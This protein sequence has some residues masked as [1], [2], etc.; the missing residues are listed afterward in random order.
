MIS[1]ISKPTDPETEAR[2]TDQGPDELLDL[3][4]GDGFRAEGEGT[5]Q[6]TCRAPANVVL[7]VGTAG[8]GKTTLLST[9]YLLFQK[10]PFAT[11][12]FAGSRTLVGLEKRVHNAR[13]ASNL[14]RPRTE[15]STFSELLHIRVRK[16][17]RSA[18]AKDVLLCDL[19]GEDFREARDS[20]DGCKRLM[21]IRRADTFVLLVNGAKLAKL[22]TRQQAKSDPIAIMRNVLDCGMLTET[23]EVDV[24]HTQWDL[25]MR[26][27]AQK[28]IEAF[29]DHVD[30]EIRRHFSSRVGSLRFARVA[31][32]SEEGTL[33]LGHGL[34]EPFQRWVDTPVGRARHLFR[35][36]Q[37][38]Q[39]ACEYDRY[40]DRYA[41]GQTEEVAT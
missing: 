11:Y 24:L 9:L 25:V 33:P 39:G 18:P 35:L 7:F 31:A 1:T 40:L 27:S 3:H 13:L 29:A 12:S 22:D 28:E 16:D 14:S 30:E 15:R 19:W 21:L 32:H 34:A 20:I 2:P 23:A 8:S 41:S 5:N 37:L 4:D 38:A 17:D 10:G 6:V 26:D 36:P